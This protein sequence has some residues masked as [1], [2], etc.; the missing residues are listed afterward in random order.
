MKSASAG[1]CV[2]EVKGA[3]NLIP[4]CITKVTEGMEIL[5]NSP[6]AREAREMVMSLILATHPKDCLTVTETAIA[7]CAPGRKNGYPES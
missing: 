7:S 2:V 4:S 5:T 6:K 1:F 3:R